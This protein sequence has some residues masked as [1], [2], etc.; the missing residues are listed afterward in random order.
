MR[1]GAQCPC[2]QT[3]P[4]SCHVGRQTS[5]RCHTPSTMHAQLHTNFLSHLLHKF[6]NLFEFQLIPGLPTK[7]W[8]LKNNKFMFYHA[9]KKDRLGSCFFLTFGFNLS[10]ITLLWKLNRREAQ[11]FGSSLILIGTTINQ[12][13]A[14][15][16]SPKNVP[17]S[18]KKS[19][20][21]ELYPNTINFLWGYFLV[22]WNV[23]VGQKNIF[24]RHSMYPLVG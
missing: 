16:V 3:Q 18:H 1:V 24:L 12:A 10:C 13:N 7:G 2:R 23:F 8:F 22:K 19:P 6:K 20:K 11:R 14:Y 15:R 17:V 4:C 9:P 5:E 21:V